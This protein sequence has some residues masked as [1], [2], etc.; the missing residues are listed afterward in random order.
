MRDFHTL[1]GVEYRAKD[2]KNGKYFK[3]VQSII[4]EFTEKKLQ[5]LI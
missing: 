2:I 1:N 3:G 5:H 4:I